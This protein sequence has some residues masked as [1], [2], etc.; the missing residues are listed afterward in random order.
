MTAY[1][2]QFPPLHVMVAGYF[3]LGKKKVYTND[4]GALLGVANQVGTVTLP[5]NDSNG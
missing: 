5:M 3:G 1:W 2:E 4:L